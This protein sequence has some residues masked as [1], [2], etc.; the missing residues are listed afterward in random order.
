MSRSGRLRADF[1]ILLLTSSCAVG[2]PPLQ[3]GRPRAAAAAGHL[4]VDARSGPGPSCCVAGRG[5][6]L[7]PAVLDRGAPS[8]RSCEIVVWSFNP[9]TRFLFESYMGGN[10]QSQRA[11]VQ[12]SRI[13]ISSEKCTRC[14]L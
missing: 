11:F 1:V 14:R 9:V 4:R 12:E 6:G 5:A 8:T 2:L 7:A 3:Q 10:V 13:T